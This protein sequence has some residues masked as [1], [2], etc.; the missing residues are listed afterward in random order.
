MGA[1]Y[2]LA[3]GDALG[4][5]TQSLP[6]SLIVSQYGSRIKDFYP[7]PLDHPIAAGLPRG[8]ITDD[9]EQA[10]LLAELLIETSGIPAPKTVAQRLIAWEEAMRQRGSHDLLGPSTVRALTAILQGEDVER[11][12]QY[13]TTNGAAMRIPPLGIATPSHNLLHLVDQVVALSYVTHNTG[14]ALSGAAAVAAAIS[15]GIEGASVAEATR[16]AIRAAEIAAERGFWV[17]GGD[18]GARIEWAV[19]FLPRAGHAED[20]ADIIYRL[21]G[22]SLASQESVPAAF[23]ALALHP[24]DAW[25]VCQFA[26]ALGGD[27][28]TISA[29]AGAIGG[30]CLGFQAF[31]SWARDTVDAVNNLKLENL[32]D[33]LLTLRQSLTKGGS[34]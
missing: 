25:Q 5:P 32:A 1:L 8:R 18:V 22:T 12:G 14:L 19:S 23:A 7:A 17:A 26:A 33:A 34:R 30:A 31:P 3:I 20:P 16:Q 24:H 15:A 9:T 29:M 2:G 13:G 21:I 4:M 28:D 10:L 27:T 6:R 11:A